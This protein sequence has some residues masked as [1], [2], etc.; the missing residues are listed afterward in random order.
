MK[1]VFLSIS[2][3]W[4]AVPV[5]AGGLLTNTNQNA[6]YLR[7]LAQEGTIAV[8]SIY[9]NPAGG[10][11][12]SKGWHLSLNS[13]TAIQRR[14]IETTFAP[15]VYNRENAQRTHKFNGKALAPVIPS[16]TAS[17]N[18]DRWSLSMHVGLNGGGGKAQFNDGLG[19]FEAAYAGVMPGLVPGMVRKGIVAQMMQMG[20]TQAVAEEK[21]KETAVQY[22]GYTLNSF[23]KGRSYYFG[24][25]LGGTY[26]ITDRLAAYVGLRGIYAT[27]NYAGNVSPTAFIAINNGG[28]QPLR[29]DNYGIV[30]DCDQQG[31]GVAPIIGM[32]WLINNHW[33]VSVKYEAPT[34]IGLRNSTNIEIEPTVKSMAAGVL[35]VFEDGKKVRDDMPGLLALG[36]QY[37]LNDKLRFSAGF[38]EYFDKAATKDAFRMDGTKYNKNE[39]VRHNTWELMAGA[40]YDCC[41]LVTLSASWQRTKYSL[42]DKYMS[43]LSFNN[44]SNSIGVGIRIHPCKY[45]NVDLGYMHTFYQDNRVITSTAAGAKTDVYSRKN[46]VFGIGVNL[47]L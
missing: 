35:G 24:L 16:L 33:N 45:F 14:D 3:V 30:L 11:F 36:A 22:K 20:M 23:M 42:G 29:L 34:R 44:S 28:D 19:S 41:S 32:D 8:T 26:K 12:L 5:F 39:D 6:A 31:F 18:H 7:N 13:Q 25:Q 47:A 43:D 4:A 21:A 2:L 27:C 1:Q 15:F 40:E 9:A 46:N 10:A 17:W 38:H 37:S